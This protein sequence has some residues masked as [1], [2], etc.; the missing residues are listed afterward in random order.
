MTPHRPKPSPRPSPSTMKATS[1]RPGGDARS[2]QKPPPKARWAC[3]GPSTTTWRASA[4]RSG[5]GRR[6]A[7]ADARRDAALESPHLPPVHRRLGDGAEVVLGRNDQDLVPRADLRIGVADETREHVLP[8]PL[9]RD[10]IRFDDHA[11]A[12]RRERR[13]ETPGAGRLEGEEAVLGPEG[14][15]VLSV[16][17]D[18]ADLAV[19]SEERRVGKEGRSRGARR[20]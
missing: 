19:R 9:E 2:S 1:A 8:V 7:L 18:V 17:E 11:E 13:A 5:R 15:D 4:S 10:R 20:R 16:R 6:H 12:R 14:E 3:S